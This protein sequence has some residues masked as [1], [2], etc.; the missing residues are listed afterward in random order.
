M[1]TSGVK[2]PLDA[3]PYDLLSSD[4]IFD[5]EFFFFFQKEDIKNK[6]EK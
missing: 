1:L 4:V 2:G 6:Y 3:G 5:V